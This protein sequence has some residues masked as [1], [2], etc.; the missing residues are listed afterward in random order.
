M[1]ALRTDFLN[2]LKVL[3]DNQ[4][5][6]V[7]VGGVAMRLHGSAHVTDDL[8]IS[9]ARNNENYEYLSKAL[10]AHSGR[11]RGVP[12]DL[13]F[14]LDARTFRNTINLTLETNL[15]SLDL[16]GQPAGIDSFEHLWENSEEMD[17]G[18]GLQVKVASLED[19]IRM[20]RVVE[21]D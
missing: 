12:E 11:L 14:I 19:L 15:G 4:V 16:L 20:K 2:I 6:F 13:P 17:I 18:E 8:D 9:Y 1:I 3:H 5:R 10:H 21:E 7:V